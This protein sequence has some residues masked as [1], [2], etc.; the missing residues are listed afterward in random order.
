ML[1][2]DQARELVVSQLALDFRAHNPGEFIQGE[3]ERDWGWLFL[4]P[5]FGGGP[6]C[7]WFVNRQSGEMEHLPGVSSTDEAVAEYEGRLGGQTPGGGGT[8]G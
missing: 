2:Q 7:G 3:I 1:N 4:Y 8:A 6:P 5:S